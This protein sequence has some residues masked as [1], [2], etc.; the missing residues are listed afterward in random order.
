M[1]TINYKEII[2]NHPWIAQE[3]QAAILSPDSDGLLCGLFMSHYLNW[4]IAGF[5]DGKVL[6]LSKG[7]KSRDCIF[8]DM[9]IFR[10]N[11][12][13]VGHH[14]VMY[15]INDLPANW[16]NFDNC[17]QPNNIRGYDYYNVFEKKYPLATIHFL[18]GILGSKMKVDIP[19][20]SIC[21]LLYTDGTFK[22]LFN[23]PENCLSWLH[24][25]GG[26][27][28]ESPLY[29]IFYNDHYSIMELMF[30]L[31]DL[32]EKLGQINDG[33]RGGDKIK[34]SDSK[35]HVQG[36]EQNGAGYSLNNATKEKAEKLLHMLS[37][38]TKW[39]YKPK[40]WQWSD[41]SVYRFSKESI[42][43]GKKNYNDMIAKDPLS[44]AITS[45]LAI[46]YT[47]EKPDKLPS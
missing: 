40:S 26:D 16:K 10:K 38:L 7:L 9:E 41:M 17:I 22:N 19:K 8:L 24:F 39:D 2:K 32:F 6:V 3:G 23:Y 44:F 31:K 34:I 20:S 11:I 33:A 28:R 5:Y 15:K 36:F 14:M 21:P 47:I 4:K 43:P 30:A 45:T 1:D 13:S 42:K 18:I 35:S 12:K 46:E 27:Y 25:L 29:S 37:K